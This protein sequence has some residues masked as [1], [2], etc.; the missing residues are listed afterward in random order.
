M[1][2]QPLKECTTTLLDDHHRSSFSPHVFGPIS[3]FQDEYQ[4]PTTMRVLD[5]VGS[6]AARLDSWG[7]GGTNEWNDE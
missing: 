4:A 1:C 3:T 7:L 6:S 5:D 2:I